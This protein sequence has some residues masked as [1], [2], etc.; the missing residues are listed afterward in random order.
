MCNFYTKLIA[1]NHFLC[2]EFFCNNFGR[3]GKQFS[4]TEKVPQRT[5]A[6]KILPNFL[7]NFLVL[8]CLKTLALLGKVPSNCSENSLYCSCE[9]L[10]LV[11]FLWLLK[12]GWQRDWQ[13]SACVH[14]ARRKWETRFLPLLVLT[15]QGAAPAEGVLAIAFLEKYPRIHQDCYHSPSSLLCWSIQ[16]EGAKPQR[17]QY[18]FQNEFLKHIFLYS[19]KCEYRPHIC[20]RETSNFSRIV[21]CMYWFCVRVEETS[22]LIFWAVG[23]ACGDS[24]WLA[25]LQCA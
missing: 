8:F 16:R 9:F 23:D 13:T 14:L 4:G 11:F 25:S 24:R 12:T 15:R 2:K 10:A 20:L 3:D 6:T 19:R 21:S 1:P 17:C 5:C 18:I 7:V 22:R